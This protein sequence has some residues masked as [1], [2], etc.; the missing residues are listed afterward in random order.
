MSNVIAFPDLRPIG[1]NHARIFDEL[2]ILAYA[3]RHSQQPER[4]AEMSNRLKLAAK[5]A[6]LLYALIEDIKAEFNA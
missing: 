4:I 2:R 3:D 1:E 6:E 5:T